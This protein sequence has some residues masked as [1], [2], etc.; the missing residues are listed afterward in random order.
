MAFAYC[1]EASFPPSSDELAACAS[2]VGLTVD[3]ID[4][5]TSNKEL[6][7]SLIQ[8]EAYKTAQALIPGTPT[9]ILSGNSISTSKFK[10]LLKQVC[11]E[12]TSLNPDAETPDGCRR[13]ASLRG[14][15]STA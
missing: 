15:I 6:V 2:I 11:A 5:C 8:D 1:Y 4:G 13:A 9:I 3:D 12:F 7:A 14:S 10:S